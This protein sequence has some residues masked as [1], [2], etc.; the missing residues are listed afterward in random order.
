MARIAGIALV[1][2]AALS[3][4]PAGTRIAVA[5]PCP[6]AEVVFA[7]GTGEPSAQAGPARPSP[8]R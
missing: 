7:R 6:D 5:E 4:A 8:T 3:T 1:M 2:V